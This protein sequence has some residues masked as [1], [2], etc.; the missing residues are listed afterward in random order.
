MHPRDE[1]K[2]DLA[3]EEMPKEGK[4]LRFGRQKPTRAAKQEMKRAKAA[5]KIQHVALEAVAKLQDVE[6]QRNLLLQV[7][8]AIVRGGYNGTLEIAY[9]LLIDTPKLS[10]Q[11]IDRGLPTARARITLDDDQATK[12]LE[13]LRAAEQACGEVVGKPLTEEER[14]Q[15]AAIE[16]EA[17][18]AG[19]QD[20][21][22]YAAAVV[23]LDARTNVEP[24]VED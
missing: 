6:K 21:A 17:R 2:E 18:A 23:D 9:G 19:D 8:G 7:L 12:A 14:A 20:A 22:D 13:L 11:I 15:L 4:L 3:P 24:P 10:F 5:R 1:P 16:S